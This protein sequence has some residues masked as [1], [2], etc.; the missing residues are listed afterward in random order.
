MENLP[1]IIP[2][3]I[4][5]VGFAAI[6]LYHLLYAQRISRKYRESTRGLK[7]ALAISFPAKIY[8]SKAFVWIV[9]L[10]GVFLLLIGIAIL[11]LLVKK[12]VTG[13]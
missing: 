5:V 11:V 4:G 7:G 9:R 10:E 3:L 12:R 8:G 1:V 6:G 2:E 13:Q